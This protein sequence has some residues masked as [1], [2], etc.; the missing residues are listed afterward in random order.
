MV[1]RLAR[2]HRDPFDRLL[3][4]QALTEPAS[5]MTVDRQL[6]AYTDLVVVVERT[7]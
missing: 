3:I 5:L 7:A 6:A 1:A 2:H 4:A